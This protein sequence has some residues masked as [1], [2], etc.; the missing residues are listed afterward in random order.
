M[1]PVQH[2][3][4]FEIVLSLGE[5]LVTRDL[6]NFGQV[7]RTWNLATTYILS[8]SIKW[9]IFWNH[10]PAFNSY[11]NFILISDTSTTFD[12]YRFRHF[13][14]DE[15]IATTIGRLQSLEILGLGGCRWL[16]NKTLR[17]VAENCKKL[18]YVP[19]R[20]LI[21]YIPTLN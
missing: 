9:I 19:C 6:I 20:K 3:L 11:F 14:T 7:C 2:E 10:D 18:K 4:P 15:N 5:L 21:S 1:E 8:K 12:F 13:L 16:T 17:L